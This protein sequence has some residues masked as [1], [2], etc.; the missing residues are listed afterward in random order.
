MCSTSIKYRHHKNSGEVRMSKG[1]EHTNHVSFTQSIYA[2]KDV[3]QWATQDVSLGTK[4][5]M[6]SAPVAAEFAALGLKYVF[7]QGLSGAPYL[8]AVTGITVTAVIREL[9]LDYMHRTI[10]SGFE[11]SITT[12]LEGLNNLQSTEQATIKSSIV[13]IKKGNDSWC[14]GFPLM[15]KGALGLVISVVPMAYNAITGNYASLIWQAGITAVSVAITYSGNRSAQQYKHAL[16]DMTKSVRN[17]RNQDDLKSKSGIIYEINQVVNSYKWKSVVVEKIAGII[18]L[19]SFFPQVSAVLP[20][21]NMLCNIFPRALPEYWPESLKFANWAF[22]SGAKLND[23][24]SK[25]IE[26]K[27]EIKKIE[28]TKGSLVSPSP[29]LKRSESAELRFAA[30]D[31]SKEESKGQRNLSFGQ[32]MKQFL[33]TSYMV[34]GRI[35]FT[36]VGWSVLGVATQVLEFNLQGGMKRFKA[37]AVSAASAGAYA[38]QSVSYIFSAGFC[39]FAYGKAAAVL[40]RNLRDN[41]IENAFANSYNSNE[42]QERKH[43]LAQLNSSETLPAQYLVALRSLAGGFVPFTRSIGALFDA[44]QS[45][46]LPVY[47]AAST[48]ATLTCAG[49]YKKYFD[50]AKGAIN[51]SVLSLEHST[52]KLTATLERYRKTAIDNYYKIS[53]VKAGVTLLET[54]NKII[55][56]DNRVINDVD[57]HFGLG[58]GGGGDAHAAFKPYSDNVGF[59]HKN[60]Y[61]CIDLFQKAYIYAHG[62]NSFNSRKET[63][64]GEKA[65]GLFRKNY[66]IGAATVGVASITVN[67]ARNSIVS[68]ISSI[69]SLPVAATVAIGTSIAAAVMT[70]LYLKY[71]NIGSRK[72]AAVAAIK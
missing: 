16:T 32:S 67:Y 66:I 68:A 8:G 10:Y 2:I 41:A 26:L 5:F 17:R 25:T 3:W 27:N 12:S 56:D 71:L 70:P 7:Q 36:A 33:T 52:D 72:D 53:L 4:A 13:V 18:S 23:F 14:N 44:K 21:G 37:G 35:D 19:S 50:Q 6:L 60:Y 29:V 22:L 59:F 45:Q 38:F 30:K 63:E 64:T 42:D 46:F 9:V 24:L 57:K 55:L 69:P 61:K 62:Y 65:Y 15:I 11:S 51:Q 54:V 48:F 47:W 20:Q 43:L 58:I 34:A 49:F 31:A 1:K 40:G 28:Q 39:E